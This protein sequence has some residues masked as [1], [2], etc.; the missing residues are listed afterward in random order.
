MRGG[1][2][3]RKS[4]RQPTSTPSPSPRRQLT[5]DSNMCNRFG[6]SGFGLRV[7]DSGFR[8]YGLGY[9][10]RGSEN[11]GLGFF[12]LRGLNYSDQLIWG[13]VS[14]CGVLGEGFT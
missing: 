13:A 14:G 10:V 6:V 9:M 11:K 4:D 7:S 3:I 8:A 1:Q 5:R 12:A 2:H